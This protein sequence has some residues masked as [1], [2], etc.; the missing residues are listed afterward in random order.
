MF[1]NCTDGFIIRRRSDGALLP[2]GSFALTYRPRLWLVKSAR[3]AAKEATIKAILVSQ[4]AMR[5][6]WLF[7]G[8]PERGGKT[9]GRV[10]KVI[11]DER[12]IFPPKLTDDLL[13]IAPRV[14][15]RLVGLLAVRGD[16]G[17][18]D[19]GDE[20][21]EDGDAEDAEEAELLPQADLDFP[22]HV[23]RDKHD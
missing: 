16:D 23:E 8:T 5:N 19:D 18:A 4:S 11:H 2:D 21:D 10:K 13:D 6:G 3:A 12:G 1:R 15:P 14:E 22:E 20:H 9:G 7:R 17:D